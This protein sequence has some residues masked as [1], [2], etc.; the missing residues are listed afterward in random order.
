MSVVKL[1]ISLGVLF[2]LLK[3]AQHQGA[4]TRHPME[5]STN[6]LKIVYVLDVYS[7]S[8]S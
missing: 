4:L 6:E 3:E 5:N 2:H 7:V 1:K 8:Y